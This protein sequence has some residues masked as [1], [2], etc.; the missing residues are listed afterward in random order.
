ML[1]FLPAQT[2]K[3]SVGTFDAELKIFHYQ[4]ACVVSP[5]GLQLCYQHILIN[6]SKFCHLIFKFSNIKKAIFNYY[7]FIPEKQEGSTN[8]YAQNTCLSE[9]IFCLNKSCF[10]YLNFKNV[11]T[12]PLKT[13]K[14]QIKD[15]FSPKNWSNCQT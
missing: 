7:T 3:Y 13:I 11:N 9:I 1:L 8:F 4:Q 14:R 5:E 10:K 15:Q 6:G 2:T 12:S